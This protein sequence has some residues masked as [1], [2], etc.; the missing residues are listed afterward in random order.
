MKT[1]PVSLGLALLGTFSCLYA[2]RGFGGSGWFHGGYT[3]AQGWNKFSEALQG[4]P[5][6][7]PKSASGVLIGG[8]G[9]GYIGRIFIGGT[10]EA[11]IGGRFG[12]GFGAVQV[13]PFWRLGQKLLFLPNLK[14]GGAGYTFTLENRPSEASFAAAID[15]AGGL[16]PRTL[17]VGAGL[18]GEVA[19]ALHYFTEKGFFIG[20]EAGYLRSLQETTGWRAMGISLQNGPKIAPQRFSVRLLIGGGGISRPEQ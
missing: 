12:S 6:S 11:V 20:L 19:L 16:P 14:V 3:A 17:S 18:V 8:G 15:S 5:L 9:G 4:S 10:G 13:G 1:L 2:Q 7:Y